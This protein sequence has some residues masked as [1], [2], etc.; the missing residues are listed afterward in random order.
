MVFQI[1]LPNGSTIYNI[2]ING[3]VNKNV[4]KIGDYEN[5]A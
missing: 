1:I 2:L 5:N 4:L 3:Y